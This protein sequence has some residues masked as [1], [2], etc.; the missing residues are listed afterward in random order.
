MFTKLTL[1]HWKRNKMIAKSQEFQFGVKNNCKQ[2]SESIGHLPP[3]IPLESK[4]LQNIKAS[5]LIK[6]IVKC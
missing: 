1:F 6:S 5:L 4:G 2:I 3:L